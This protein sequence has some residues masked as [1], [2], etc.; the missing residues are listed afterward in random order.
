MTGR[1]A[2]KVVPTI[3]EAL[4]SLQDGMTVMVGGFGLSGNPEALI[5]GV[6]ERGAKHLTL[7]SNNAGNLGKGLD[8]VEKR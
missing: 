1:H 7:V 4:S 6:V 2:N 3:A 5:K 8:D